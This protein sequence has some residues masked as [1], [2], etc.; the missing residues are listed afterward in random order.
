[1]TMTGNKEMKFRFI[2]PVLQIPPRKKRR[3]SVYD[4]IINEFIESGLKCAEVKNVGRSPI[5]VCTTLN[6]R[7]KERG[8][9]NIK[10]RLRNQKVY[11]EKVDIQ[12]KIQHNGTLKTFLEPKNTRTT[13]TY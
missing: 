4:E 12:T 13:P 10:A 1:M 9:K 3:R 2:E 5:T 11:L 8:F 7:L 6:L